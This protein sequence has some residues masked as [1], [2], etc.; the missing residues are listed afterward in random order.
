[1]TYLYS[2]LQDVLD[3]PASTVTLI[4]L[5]CGVAMVIIR[6][7]LAIPAMVFLLGPITFALSILANYVFARLELFALTQADQWLIATIFSATVG[8]TVGLCIGAVLARATDKS[9]SAQSRFHKA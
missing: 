6:N 4:G 2:Y 8:V 9:Q 7:K 3:I 1:M 5:M